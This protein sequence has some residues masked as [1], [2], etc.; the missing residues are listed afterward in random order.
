MSKENENMTNEEYYNIEQRNKY[1]DE[2]G[3]EPHSYG[4]NFTQKHDKREKDWK[5]QREDYGFDERETWNLN[6][7]FVEWLYCRCKMYVEKASPIVNL[8]Y[9]K[10]QFEGKEYTQIEAIEYIIEKCEAYMKTKYAYSEEEDKNIAGM[11]KAIKLWS[12]VFPAMWW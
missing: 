12:E 9:Y 4:T 1:L 8:K 6:D 7:Q 10:F 3:I 2:L 11:Q 5:K